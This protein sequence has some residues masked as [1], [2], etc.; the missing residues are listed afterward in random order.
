MTNPLDMSHSSQ[1]ISYKPSV[2]FCL[3]ACHRLA[4]LERLG[5][6]SACSSMFPGALF[7][8]MHTYTHQD[9]WLMGRQVLRI[10][11]GHLRGPSVFMKSRVPLS[12]EESEN[13]H[14]T[15][16]AGETWLWSA[17]WSRT[18][19]SCCASLCFPGWQFGCSSSF[20]AVAIPVLPPSVNVFYPFL[21]PS[22]IVCVFWLQ[23]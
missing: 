3:Q 11:V 21:L 6:F 4:S 2:A 23:C 18:C 8:R 17:S 20:T 7:S 19:Q 15:P 5:L 10:H 13:T 1:L 14:I 12:L 22:F 9:L 16:V